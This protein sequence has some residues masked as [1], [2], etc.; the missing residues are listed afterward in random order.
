MKL[1]STIPSRDGSRRKSS[2][3]TTEGADPK[4]QCPYDR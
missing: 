2:N 4:G 1:V 3:R